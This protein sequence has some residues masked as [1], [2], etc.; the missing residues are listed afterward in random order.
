MATATEREGKEMLRLL[1]VNE[2]NAR[3][4][5]RADQGIMC[6]KLFAETKT[7]GD[8]PHHGNQRVVDGHTSYRVARDEFVVEREANGAD[9][10]KQK[11]IDH[12]QQRD[13]RQ[14]SSQQQTGNN[15]QGTANGKTVAG[16]GKNGDMALKTTR[17]Q[18]G[19]G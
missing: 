2:I 5:Q 13:A 16:A 12:S 11:Q 10:D 9:A 15:E 18:R 19:R 7:T 14:I 4:S 17:Q 6:I 3:S 8:R 1:A